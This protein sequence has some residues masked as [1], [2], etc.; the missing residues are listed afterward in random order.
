MAKLDTARPVLDPNDMPKLLQRMLMHDI[1][2]YNIA[3]LIH[4]GAKMA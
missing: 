4:V 3:V 1:G 2:G